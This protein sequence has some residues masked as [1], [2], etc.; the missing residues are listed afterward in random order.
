MR[1][2]GSTDEYL[3]TRLHSPHAIRPMA[4]LNTHCCQVLHGDTQD[5]SCSGTRLLPK[6]IADLKKHFLQLHS[7]MTCLLAVRPG[8]MKLKITALTCVAPNR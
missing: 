4:I 1:K 7:C 3:S 5:S 8:D 2:A 6:A